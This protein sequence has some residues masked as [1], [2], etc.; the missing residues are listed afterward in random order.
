MLGILLA[1]LLVSCKVVFGYS[2][3]KVVVEGSCEVPSGRCR[4]R[5]IDVL[6]GL[7]KV[8]LSTLLSLVTTLASFYI[9]VA[10]PTYYS[11]PSKLMMA[12]S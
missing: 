12:F 1:R 10:A 7:Q 9:L 11:S 5:K 4:I 8:H 2:R 6:I 3:S